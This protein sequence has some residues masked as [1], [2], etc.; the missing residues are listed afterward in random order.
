VIRVE[1]R[2]NVP[3][4]LIIAASVIAALVTLIITVFLSA[5]A[6]VSAFSFIGLMFSAA[7]G[8]LASM[9][10]L[11]ALAAPLMLTGLASALTFRVGLINLG[12]EGQIIAA[13]L[14][15]LVIS[16]RTLPVPTFAIVP[17]AILAG[18]MTGALIVAAVSVLKLKFRADEAVMTILLNIVMVF[19]LQ[20]LTG[21]MTGSLPPVGSA[22][23]MPM[24]NA[25]DFPDWGQLLHRYL[26]PLVAVV[27]C[28]LSFA[29]I[30]FTIWGLDIR[31]TGGNAVAARFAGIHVNLVRLN[32]AL[33]AGALVG[34]AGTGQVVAAGGGT[35]PSLT[36]GLGYAGISVA[37]LAALEPVGV[38]P[39][40]FFVSFVLAGIK[41]ANQEMG[42][43]LALGSV[44]TAL[45]LLA[46]LVS[47]GS[48]RYR[49][50]P[51][52]RSVTS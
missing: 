37:F 48:V 44:V 33:F 31:A 21:A 5:L 43:P 17:L 30:R 22:Q 41:A 28:L 10:D 14:A 8:S 12:A 16:A 29:V 52:S 27:A 18:T 4:A 15:A 23:V 20:L 26:E 38:I 2:A 50:R 19:A 6:G 40:A 3:T 51:R 25:Y 46:A 9:I 7:F 36:L 24:I 32:V 45:L 11:L 39:A 34:L 42:L 1:R 13:A 35:A 49:L 47:H